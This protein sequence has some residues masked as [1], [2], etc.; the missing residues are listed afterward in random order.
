MRVNS[1]YTGFFTNRLV[2]RPGITLVMLAVFLIATSFKEHSDPVLR[3]KQMNLIIR[4]I[5]HRLLQQAGD[6]TSRVFPVTEVKKGTFKLSF[7]NK[8]VFNH[9]SLMAL[10]K[11]LLPKTQYPSGYIVTVHDCRTGGMVYG[12]QLNNSS[13]DLLACSGRSQPAGC[14]TIEFAFP[15]FYE[16]II[17]EKAESDQL[18][19][20]VKVDNQET[21]R[22]LVVNPKQEELKTTTFSNDISQQAEGPKSDKDDSGEI[23][24]K[25]EELTATIFGYPLSYVVFGGILLLLG[26]AL[27]IQRFGKILKPM[28]V[29]NQEYAITEDP[30]IGQENAIVQDSAIIKESIQELPSLG[31]FVFN[32]KTQCL[33]LGSE[34]INLSDKECK[35]LALLHKNFG[36]LI[37]RE[38]M[39]QEIW[40]NEGVITGRSLDMFVSKLRKK[41]SPDPELR[42]TNVHGK[43]YKLEITGRQIV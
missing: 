22:R 21:N 28:P 43:G 10:S 16:D 35:V 14:Y 34:E 32:V 13:P 25:R 7:E 23:K 37:P 17:K 1:V 2:V 29:P 26:V 3:A 31:N 30:A 39:L 41:L 33:L 5:G 24:P 40:I 42:I 4:Q 9:D 11:S 20:S 12:F 6:S 38:T 18:T 27:F 36:E 19:E 15:D 8:F